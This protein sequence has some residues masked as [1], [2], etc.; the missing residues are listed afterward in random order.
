M[1]VR[2]GYKRTEVGVIPEEW[3]IVSLSEDVT[4]LSGHHVLAS[5]CNTDG[6]GVP[7]VTGPADFPNG[8][9]QHT[10]YTTSPTTMCDANDILVTVKGSGVGKLVLSDAEYCISRQLMAIRVDT[11]ST[12]YIY[13]SLL[14]DAA[15][16]RERLKITSRFPGADGV[17]PVG[18][19]LMSF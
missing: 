1:E 19:G 17:V 4:L 13:Y 16:L 8:V 15:A 2:P 5:Q 11:W 12:K 10:K 7:Y 9:I 3:E 6:E 14:Q 18:T